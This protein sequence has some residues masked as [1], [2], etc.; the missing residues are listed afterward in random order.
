MTTLMN[1]NATTQCIWLSSSLGHELQCHHPVHL[2]IQSLG[3]RIAI[4]PPSAF[5]Y[6]LPSLT[7]CNATTQCIWLSTPLTHKLQCHH[8]VHLPTHSLGPLS[9]MPPPSAFDSTPLTLLSA[10]PP[11]G[12]FHTPPLPKECKNTTDKL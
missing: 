12:I 5:G 11:P 4:P 2:V 8:P 10:M 9:A 7:N 1:C 3:S 6:P